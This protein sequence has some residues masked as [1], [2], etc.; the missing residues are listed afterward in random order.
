MCNLKKYNNTTKLK[1]WFLGFIT[2]LKNPKKT[3]LSTQRQNVI[4]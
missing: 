2:K 3:I 4:K 1:S